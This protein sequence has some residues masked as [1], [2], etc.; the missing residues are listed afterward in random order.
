MVVTSRRHVLT[1][2]GASITGAVLSPFVVACQEARET[3]AGAF[4]YYNG[5][6]FKGSE[7]LRYDLTSDR[8]D[9][10]YP[11]PITA[12]WPGLWENGI[13]ASILWTGGKA[14]FFQGDQYIR[15]DVWDRRV[16]SGYPKPIASHWPGLWESDIDTGMLWTQG[17][18]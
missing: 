1:I 11:K 13:N 10:G 6:F 14:Y 17:K 7:Y 4:P 15:Y 2:A 12:G 9:T 3:P 8:A 18:L 16:D 5:Y